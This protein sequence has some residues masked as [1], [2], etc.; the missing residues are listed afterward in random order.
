MKKLVLFGAGK[1]GRSFIGQLFAVSGYEVVFVD[2]SEQIV[3]ELNKRNEYSVVIKSAN[4]DE[5]IKVGNVRGIPEA[6][7]KR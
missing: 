3:R 5:I 7:P 6:K 1:I 4:A 2:V